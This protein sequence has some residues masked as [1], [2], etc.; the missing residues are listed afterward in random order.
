MLIIFSL[1]AIILTGYAFHNWHQ[2]RL[3]AARLGFMALWMLLL[4]VA[5]L[6]TLRINRGT[7]KGDVRFGPDFDDWLGCVVLV[8]ASNVTAAI[9]TL[10]W[11]YNDRGRAYFW[12]ALTLL[13]VGFGIYGFRD[14]YSFARWG[15]RGE[16][17]KLRRWD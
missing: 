11:Q 12:V 14:S 1:A 15:I 10:C 16:E 9:A 4:A 8:S 7:R 17:E 2:D 13:I 3:W 6:F 5:E